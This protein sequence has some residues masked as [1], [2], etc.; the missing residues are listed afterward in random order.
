[1]CGCSN[2]NEA[3]RRLVGLDWDGTQDPVVVMASI[4]LLNGTN[5]TEASHKVPA[6]A[7]QDDER[8]MCYLATAVCDPDHPAYM[9]LTILGVIHPERAAKRR[10]DNNVGRDIL[11]IGHSCR[12]VG[13][14]NIHLFISVNFGLNKTF[15]TSVTSDLVH[16]FTTFLDY[17]VYIQE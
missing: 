6:P 3:K 4:N 7:Q 17:T 10:V 8:H 5:Y 1:M 9:V 11:C 2:A 13:L 15:V 16:V 12:P 14:E